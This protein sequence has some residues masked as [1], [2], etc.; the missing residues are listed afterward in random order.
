MRTR[1]AVIVSAVIGAVAVGWVLRVGEPPAER[2]VAINERVTHEAIGAQPDRTRADPSEA[3]ARPSPETVNVEDRA[4]FNEQ[5][6][7]FFAQAPA[8]PPEEARRRA[9]VLAQELSRIERA[10]GMSAGETFLLR[11]GLI[12]AGEVD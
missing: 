11:L 5:A 4:R 9:T 12:R 1:L 8:L 7:E 2:A 10:G 3:P 6:R